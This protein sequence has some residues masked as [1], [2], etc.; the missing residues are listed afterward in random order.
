VVERRVFAVAGAVPPAA[1]PHVTPQSSATTPPGAVTPTGACSPQMSRTE[2][3]CTSYVEASGAARVGPLGF[4][5]ATLEGPGMY[6]MGIIDP[7]QR[8]T[9]DKRLE[10]LS[11]IVFKC[12][13]GV[14]NGMSV[15]PP[16]A[17]ARRFHAMVGLK[18]LGMSKKQ[19]DDDWNAESAR[20]RHAAM[21]PPA[22]I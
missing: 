16:D 4:S 8:F 11:K 22:R 7:L 9:W 18:L 21:F 5:T 1:S 17:Y 19:V 12:R 14:A 3:P 13:C 10:R 2:T 20:R 15:L 6:Q